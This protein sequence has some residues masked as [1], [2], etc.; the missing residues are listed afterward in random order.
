MT[1]TCAECS[2]RSGRTARDGRDGRRSSFFCGAPAVAGAPSGASAVACPFGVVCPF[3][4]C[5]HAHPSEAGGH[6][7]AQ[8]VAQELDP[9]GLVACTVAFEE[10]Y[11]PLLA[12][13][14]A[15]RDKSL[16]EFV[17]QRRRPMRDEHH[18]VL[19]TIGL[20]TLRR[21]A[22]WDRKGLEAGI[23]ELLG[24][25]VTVAKRNV[26]ALRKATELDLPAEPSDAV[27]QEC[28]KE[29][30]GTAPPSNATADPDADVRHHP[31][32]AMLK[33]ALAK[34]QLHGP[35]EWA[36]LGSV[37]RLGAWASV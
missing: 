31:D 25:D 19:R 28:E 20:M 5:H 10:R 4:T 29:A 23:V 7:L 27:A 2:P 21:W 11:T 16:N 8:Y 15:H 33:K 13:V 9:V 18:Y 1:R 36:G 12:G 37:G 32:V 6:S 3:S 30:D 24:C 17:V 34:V 14:E 22:L 26:E 35:N